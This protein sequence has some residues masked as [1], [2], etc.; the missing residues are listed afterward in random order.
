MPNQKRNAVHVFTGMRI[1]HIPFISI[2]Q[3][4]LTALYPT[5]VPGK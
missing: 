2:L 1:A 3:L 4:T 5:M